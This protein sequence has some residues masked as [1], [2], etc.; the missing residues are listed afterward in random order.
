V[1]WRVATAGMPHHMTLSADGQLLFVPYFNSTW[2]A[3]I[4]TAAHAVVGKLEASYGSHATGLSSDGKH[5]YVGSMMNSDLRV[6]DVATRQPIGHL[7]TRDGVRPFKLASDESALYVQ[8]SGVHGFDVLDPTSGDLLRTV[9]LPPLKDT[10]TPPRF[11]PRTVDHGLALSHDGT[12]LLAAGSIEGYVAAYS[13]PD[14]VLL[15]TVAVGADPN[16][17]VF[18]GDDKLAYVSDRGS[19]EV[20]I[21]AL[22]D[23]VEIQRIKVGAYPQRLAL[24][25]IM[26]G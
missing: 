9:E 1:L 22:P 18:S 23:L 25:S 16:W 8:L 3:V 26:G 19:N 21:L 4:D 14:L 17:I 15:G 20:S 12:L 13:V 5:L 24:V 11:F 2:V 6:Y 7:A 10:T